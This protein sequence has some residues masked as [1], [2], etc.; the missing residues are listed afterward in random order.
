VRRQSPADVIELVLAVLL[1]VGSLSPWI[2]IS[3]LSVNGTD[4]WWGI[5]T[6]FGSIA[7]AFHAVTRLWPGSFDSTIAGVSR[8]GALVGLAAS[9]AILGYVGVRLVEASR[10]FS[11]DI[12]TTEA[13]VTDDTSGLGEEFDDA[14]E[15]FTQSLTELLDPRLALGWYLST[16]SATAGLVLVARSSRNDDE[17]PPPVLNQDL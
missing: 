9:L 17:L 11:T 6:L 2:T 3:F 8:I 15:E 16:A 7:L 5:V 13:Q 4:T 12:G 1:L 14:L 10:Q